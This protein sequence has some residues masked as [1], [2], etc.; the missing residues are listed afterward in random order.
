MMRQQES[1]FKRTCVFCGSSQGNKT[2]YHDA[3][4]NLAKELQVARGI[5]LVYGG[6]GIGLMGLVIPRTLMT[7][8]V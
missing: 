7:P 3:A 1:R 4:I 5:D 6:G 2:S 8:E